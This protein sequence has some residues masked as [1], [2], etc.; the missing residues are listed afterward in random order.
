MGRGNKLFKQRIREQQ[1]IEKAKSEKHFKRVEE[2]EKLKNEHLFLFDIT[3]NLRGGV[4]LKSVK[5]TDNDFDLLKTIIKDYVSNGE[6][7]EGEVIP[8]SKFTD[9]VYDIRVNELEEKCYLME[10]C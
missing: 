9:C 4:Y 6:L 7:K 2:K 10:V 5:F 1:E 8:F 3:E